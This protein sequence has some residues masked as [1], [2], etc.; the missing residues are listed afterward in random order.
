VAAR[1]VEFLS[2]PDGAGPTSLYAV[3]R[4]FPEFTEAKTTDELWFGMQTK[5]A[6]FKR[7]CQVEPRLTTWQ[8]TGGAVLLR[9]AAAPE[10]EVEDDL[11]PA[12]P[13]RP[14]SGL[15][16]T[17]PEDVV[18]F[19]ADLLAA[20]P[21]PIPLS[22][23]AMAIEAEFGEGVRKSRWLGHK[24]LKTL[25]VQKGAGQGLKVGGASGYL[26]DGSRHTGEL[27]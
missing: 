24:N 5:D 25:L 26:Y 9:L 27:K 20:S 22:T 2:A 14:S 23:V 18:K 21:I 8:N 7:L 15:P 1:I 10:A 3:L 11:A 17:T 19:A 16:A 13:H 12:A 6:L 4:E